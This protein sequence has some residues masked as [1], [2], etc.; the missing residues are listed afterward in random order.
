MAITIIKDY[1]F[2]FAKNDDYIYL[3]SDKTNE[4]QYRYGLHLLYDRFTTSGA[5]NN[6]TLSD[7]YLDIYTNDVFVILGYKPNTNVYLDGIGNDYRQFNPVPLF[8]QKIEDKGSGNYRLFFD[9]DKLKGNSIWWYLAFASKSGSIVARNFNIYKCITK[10]VAA[11]NDGYGVFSV[12]DVNRE[13]LNDNIINDNTTDLTL[14]F[15]YLPFEEYL[16][17]LNYDVTT[18]TSTSINQFKVINKD[19]NVDFLSFASGDSIIIENDNETF[20]NGVQKC[21]SFNFGSTDWLFNTDKPALDGMSVSGGVAYR[22]DYTA[23]PLTVESQISNYYTCF[24]SG[25]KLNDVSGLNNIE[26]NLLVDSYI[27]GK[28]YFSYS[29]IEQNTYLNDLGY[30]TIANNG[31]AT[32]TFEVTD[33]EN[34]LHNYTLSYSNSDDV[35]K[36]VSNPA[37][38]NNTSMTTNAARG[39]PVIQECDKSYTITNDLNTIIK[40]YTLKKDNKFER[41]RLLFADSL[42]SLNGFNFALYNAKEVKTEKDT[43]TQDYVDF[44]NLNTIKFNNQSRG[45]TDIAT[46]KSYR[47][48]LNSDFLTQEESNYFED[49]L[50][51]NN[52]FA[53]YKGDIIAVNIPSTGVTIKEKINGLIRYSI[54]VEYSIKTTQW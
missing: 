36:V 51:S 54:K 29:P 12:N 9:I 22:A 41:V 19:G 3:D 1:T 48:T 6:R 47:L 15:R 4:L 13:L 53:Q 30:L 17:K 21:T 5:M 14:K 10:K 38:I 42:G 34:V 37:S 31:A 11:N 24:Y 18:T 52:V 45:K 39:L 32:F 49:L 2:P 27:N 28:K 35:F 16:V 20:Y 7:G 23:T 33:L 50:T 8:L 43:Y 26:L 40:T 25:L 44:N 46:K